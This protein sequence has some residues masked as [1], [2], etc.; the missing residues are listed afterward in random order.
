MKITKVEL[1]PVSLPRS[2]KV[3]SIVVIKMHTDEG[4]VGVADAGEYGPVRNGQHLVMEIVKT[5]EPILIGANPLDRDPSW[6]SCP[7]LSIPMSAWLTPAWW[8]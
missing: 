1:F 8:P 5:W 4:I 7:G 6:A 2:K 3:T